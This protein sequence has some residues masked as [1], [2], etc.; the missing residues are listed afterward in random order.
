MTTVPKSI[1][2]PRHEHSV[3]CFWPMA[4]A[5]ELGEEGLTLFQNNLRFVEKAI[6]F[7]DPPDPEWVTENRIVL[8]LDTLRLRDFSPLGQNAAQTPVLVDA[9][10]AGHSSTI[11]DY[12]VG[13]SLV[14]TLMAGGLTQVLVT[15]WKSATAAMKD[16]DI[17]T[18]LADI[19]R[20]VDHLGG[21]VD[22]V[23]LCQGG[24]MSA[25]Y[26]AR[27]PHKVGCLVL[28]GAPIDTDAGDGPIKK[29]AHTLPLSLYEQMVAAGDGRM[30]GQTMLAGWKGMNADEQYLG[31]FIDLYAHI[32][33]KN[34][35]RRTEHFE[36]WYENPIDLPG[37]YY[38][39]TIQQIFKENRLAKGEFVGLGQRLSL[40]DIVC[41]VYLLAG[42]EDDITTKEQV[43]DA[44]KY[45][46]TPK[47]DIVKKL[48]AG[49]HIGLFMGSRTLT[50]CWPQIALWLRAG[51]RPGR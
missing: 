40:K 12:A 50:E 37:A 44:E 17:D 1:H 3:P 15:D 5:I 32:E 6:A 43:F 8:E 20:V 18:Y 23:G 25:M 34:F 47:T 11:A 46:G 33:D 35:L 9:P 24:W 27:F 10:Y 16:F 45:L 38:L 14:E 36:R 19:D 41:P 7:G 21:K 26:A 49:G 42:S 28:A 31:K 48:V 13:Q 22:L 51:G 30:L 2:T 29:L 39:Q 4:A